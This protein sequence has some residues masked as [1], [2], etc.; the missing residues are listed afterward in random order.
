MTID[1]TLHQFGELGYLLLG[2]VHW[3]G[4]SLESSWNMEISFSINKQLL[5]PGRG[6]CLS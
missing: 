1:L 4:L 6:T 3:S 5:Y 2:L